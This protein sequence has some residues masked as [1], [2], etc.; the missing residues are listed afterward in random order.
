MLGDPNFPEKI[1]ST[2]RGERIVF[3]QDLYKNYSRLDFTRNEDRPIAISGLERRLIRDLR[4]QGGFGVF[5]DG[6]S[7]L[8]RTLLW[9][10]GKD[11]VTLR[12]ISFPP[13]RKVTVP[14][15][16]WTAYEGGID[17]LDL[18][19]GGVD[20]EKDVHS[21]W[22]PDTAE[23]YHTTD[24][25]GSVELSARAR[26]FD[27]RVRDRQAGANEFMIVYDSPQTEGKPL[28]CVVMGRRRSS[29]GKPE[30]ARHY[31]LFVAPK[32]GS[33][34]VYERVGVGFMPGDFL[35]ANTSGP[36]TSV[37]VR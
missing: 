27:V 11:Q 13:E 24:R 4:A 12:R 17:F 3:Y 8:Q 19:L 36:W 7:L 2:T 16:S 15:W 9:Q 32:E 21:P 30:Q 18:P 26:A 1:T 29:G 28:K 14:T 5:D 23:G 6:Q 37:K 22:I 10:R 34:H 35:G 33:N 31:V 20:W 25:D